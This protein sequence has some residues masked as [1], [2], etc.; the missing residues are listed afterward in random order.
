MAPLEGAGRKMQNRTSTDNA[1]VLRLGEGAQGVHF[2]SR[3]HTLYLCYTYS[4]VCIKYQVLKKGNG[5]EFCQVSH[6][7]LLNLE[8][9]AQEKYSVRDTTFEK[10]LQSGASLEGFVASQEQVSNK[11]GWN[12][13]RIPYLCVH[14]HLQDGKVLRAGPLFS[15]PCLFGICIHP[16]LENPHVPHSE[17]SV[18][19]MSW[20][21]VRTGMKGSS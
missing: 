15:L 19:G 14:L 9:D 18:Q 11:G 12:A 6:Y 17:K 2:I 3:M 21:E 10:I 1:S 4:S 7:L 8:N 20:R 13:Q 16:T 5:D